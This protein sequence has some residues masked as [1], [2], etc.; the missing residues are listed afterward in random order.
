MIKLFE[1]TATDYS[2]LGYGILNDVIKCDVEEERNGSFELDMEYPI[3]GIHYENI[4]LRNIIVCK[5][6][7]FSNDQA[8]RIYYI[9]KPINGIVNIK[10]EHISY[11][12]SGFVVSPF[13][14]NTAPSALLGLK[15]NATPECNFS[16]TSDREL[17]AAFSVK[18]PSSLRSLLGGVEGSIL[19]VYGPGEYEFDNFNVSLK[20][21][22]GTDRGVVVRYG[23][24]LTDLTQEENCTKV[25]TA[26][27]PYWAGTKYEN[28]QSTDILITLPEKTVP[29]EGTFDFERIYPLDLGD[30]FQNEQPTEEQLRNEAK[31]Y[32]SQNG[33]GKPE[34]SLKISFL[35]LEQA[36]EFEQLRLLERV[37]LCDE[38]TVIFE[39][40]GVN[41]TAKCIKTVYNAITDKYESL[42]FGDSRTNLANTIVNQT[43]AIAKAPTASFMEQEAIRASKLITGGLGGYAILHSSSGRL[44]P[45]E[46]LLLDEE[47]GGDYTKAQRLWRFNKE[48]FG[49]SEDGYDGP[50]KKLAGTSDGIFIADQVKASGIQAGTIDA[51][52]KITSP[53]INGGTISG[54]LIEA[55]TIGNGDVYDETKIDIKAASGIR[56]AFG[57]TEV[58]PNGLYIVTN[59]SSSGSH[60]GVGTVRKSTLDSDKRDGTFLHWDA[61]RL[62]R[63]SSGRVGWEAEFVDPSDRRLKDNIEDVPI[64]KVRALFQKL[65]FKQFSFKEDP[66]SRTR[67]GLI[68]QDV[69]ETLDEIGLYKE[70]TV[71]DRGDGYLKLE[72]SRLGRFA[73]PAIQDLY[74]QIDDLQSQINELKNQNG[75]KL[76]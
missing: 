74:N 25:Y 47:S 35:Q 24:N 64:S 16:F 26:V 8:F 27:Y 53:T 5:S 76:E 56:M 6:N 45:D 59:N 62:W 67:Y 11:D 39:K 73:I 15:D 38:V 9:S 65:K 50:Y 75:G 22:R 31:N 10:A 40:L 17:E 19:D 1:S 29:V 36:E 2:T 70:D 72:Y 3:D 43:E 71:Y 23:K 18:V 28:E 42:E 33:I 46:L 66:G 4:A 69:E 7:P 63:W 37:N 34:V 20:T 49:Y 21:H 30:K 32:I 12:L 60:D 48:G 51:E 13:N 61:V 55:S 41:S 58:F 54:A 57:D 14:A 44:E 52:I 68:A